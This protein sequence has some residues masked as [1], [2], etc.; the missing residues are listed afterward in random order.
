ME[1]LAVATLEAADDA[2]YVVAGYS[3]GGALAHGLVERLEGMGN[4]PEGLVLLDAYMPFG[5][6]LA[7]LF[8]A[9]VGRLMEM[10]DEAIALDDDHLLAMGG[11][12]RVLGEWQPGEIA[13]PGL[14]LRVTGGARA[15]LLVGED[16]P[17]WQQMASTVDVP[18]DHFEIIAATAAKTA[19]A[20]D[21]WVSALGGDR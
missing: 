16:L 17:A 13:A 15:A 3:S 20:I 14:M 5:E 8:S 6:V 7:E 19:A 21:A 2:P 4:A 12:L 9:D 18:G 10:G 1:A 11:Y